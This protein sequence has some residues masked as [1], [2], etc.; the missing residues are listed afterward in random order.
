M[1]SG[2]TTA[3]RRAVRRAAVMLRVVQLEVTCA[4]LLPVVLQT[5]EAK[6]SRGLTRSGSSN[7]PRQT[8]GEEKLERVMSTE[9]QLEGDGCLLSGSTTAVRCLVCCLAVCL[10]GT[11]ACFRA[12]PSRYV[13]VVQ[14]KV[15]VTF[16]ALQTRCNEKLNEPRRPSGRAPPSRSVERVSNM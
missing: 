5:R 16:L 4:W 1:L 6:K 12:A 3:A 14:L 13:A 8:M 10:R 2:C 9:K 7:R 15:S 11:I